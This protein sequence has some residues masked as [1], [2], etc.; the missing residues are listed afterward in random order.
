MS[1]CF[2]IIT[3]KVKT[4]SSWLNKVLKNFYLTKKFVL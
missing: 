4:V 2:I 3:R 1:C